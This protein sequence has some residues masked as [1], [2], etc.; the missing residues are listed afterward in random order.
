MLGEFIEPDS[1][2]T[3]WGL[4]DLKLL[5]GVM[6]A[7][8]V[9]G[10]VSR[11]LNDNFETAYSFGK[12]QLHEDP[13]SLDALTARLTLLVTVSSWQLQDDDLNREVEI[14]ARQVLDICSPRVKASGKD[15]RALQNCGIANFSLSYVFSV[16]GR[17]MAAARRATRSIKQ[18]EA[19][20][21]ADPTKADTKLHLGLLY[22]YTDNLP[23]FVKAVGWVV[24]FIPSGNGQLAIPYIIEVVEKDRETE[25][26]SSLQK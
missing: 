20:L 11:Y 21:D 18:L 4:S 25:S 7:S 15:T 24:W 16:Q 1:K 5:P 8:Q 10:I 13:R 22:H 14:T 9:E 6:A 23:A 19:V 2:E 12:V 17:Y 3:H 26:L